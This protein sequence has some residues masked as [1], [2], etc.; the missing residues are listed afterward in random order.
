MVSWITKPTQ[1]FREI[2]ALLAKKYHMQIFWKYECNPCDVN[3]EKDIII[4]GS[5]DRFLQKESLGMKYT[6]M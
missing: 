4:I 5:N 6:K 1:F 3:F 2:V